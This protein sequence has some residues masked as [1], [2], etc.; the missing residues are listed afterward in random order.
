MLLSPET[1]QNTLSRIILKMHPAGF[2]LGKNKLFVSLNHKAWRPISHRLITFLH[3]IFRSWVQTTLLPQEEMNQSLGAKS[4]RPPI[5]RK[6]SSPNRKMDSPHITSF[7][8]S[9]KSEQSSQ[10]CGSLLNAPHR[11][12]GYFF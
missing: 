7:F 4:K 9:Y 5:K 11:I 1:Q 3:K 2:F 12:S 6:G 10:G 8:S